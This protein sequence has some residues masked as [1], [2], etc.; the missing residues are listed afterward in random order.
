MGTPGSGAEN[1]QYGGLFPGTIVGKLT[2]IENLL[3]LHR[4]LDITWYN[5][6]CF[7]LV[8]SNGT[9]V[10]FL[11]K[12]HSGDPIDATVETRFMSSATVQASYAGSAAAPTT[13]GTF[14][15]Q[16]LPPKWGCVSL[17][18]WMAVAHLPDLQ[19]LQLHASPRGLKLIDVD[20]SLRANISRESVTSTIPFLHQGEFRTVRS[21]NLVAFWSAAL[22]EVFCRATQGSRSTLRHV[23]CITSHDPIVLCHVTSTGTILTI[24]QSIATGETWLR[25][26][27]INPKAREG[28]EELDSR[29]EV[30]Q[31]PGRVVCSAVSPV[32][33]CP[34]SGGPTK[35]LAVSIVVGV[36]T[37]HLLHLLVQCQP[38]HI[39]WSI[40]ARAD[41]LEPLPPVK[42]AIHPLGWLFA[43]IYSSGRLRLLDPCFHPVPICM[44]GQGLSSAAID[45]LQQLSFSSPPSHLS[46]SVDP[47]D[48]NSATSS[49]LHPHETLVAVF[50]RGPITVLHV[51]TAG[52]LTFPA[53]VRYLSQHHALDTLRTLV[54]AWPTVTPTHAR[55]A[56]A[57]AQAIHHDLTVYRRTSAFP[58]P[59]VQI[60][61]IQMLRRLAMDSDPPLPPAELATVV[62][63]LRTVVHGQIR[64][65]Q[66]EPALR[67]I[68][69]CDPS[70]TDLTDLLHL[71]A[72]RATKAGSKVV[73]AAA[74]RL[75]A[76]RH[77]GPYSPFLTQCPADYVGA[78][79]GATESNEDLP[80]TSTVEQIVE[81]YAT[82][83]TPLALGTKRAFGTDV[84]R[85]AA[86]YELR[87]YTGDAKHWWRRLRN[88]S[89]A[90][91]A[92]QRLAELELVENE[93][94]GS[95]GSVRAAAPRR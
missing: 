5:K 71:V 8:L 9:I 52:P 74:M 42:L 30:L 73:A 55:D 75:F 63:M 57:L 15:S 58:R 69:T 61:L 64:L 22:V 4:P 12:Q 36:E 7:H 39:N 88:D 68:L 85:L 31:F 28:G 43:A 81:Y 23:R 89:E 92:M 54:S 16:Q 20:H 46:W 27:A 67:T 50:E 29:A 34:L 32:E 35:S 84:K 65:A 41:P 94:A 13:A 83:I 17:S 62:A 33:H 80:A 2:E 76:T 11:L 49:E 95:G 91:R 45:L 18:G 70:G 10:Q 56:V 77:P 19:V 24:V 86:Y 66:F 48:P 6:S 25:G 38:T 47:I 60:D 87:G 26:Y 40:L 59:H 93:S 53:Y 79:A 14:G 72:V 44:S 78:G 82:Q 21:R 51:P 3:A 90:Q 1:S 37:G